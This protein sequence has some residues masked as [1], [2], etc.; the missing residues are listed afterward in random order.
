[1]NTKRLLKDLNGNN[2]GKLKQYIDGLNKEPRIAWYPSSGIDF[3]ALLFLSKQFSEKKPASNY[4]PDPPDL[5]IYTDYFLCEKP[6]F[7][8]V[9][10]S[11]TDNGNEITTESV[12]ELPNLDLQ[13]H[14]EIV[15]R[16]QGQKEITNRIF[17]LNIKIEN[18][19][20][21]SITFPVL[22]AFVEN[23]TFCCE[24]LIPNKTT[25]SQIIHVRY[26]GGC[27]GGGKAAGA[28]LL[29][30]LNTLKCGLFIT[31]GHHD[32][33]DGDFAAEMLYEAI[34]NGKD[35]KLTSIKVINEK[36]WSYHGNVSWNLVS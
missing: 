24:R 3:K 16:P 31:D 20:Y 9:G 21:G 5:F 28:W 34:R 36:R 4:V 2:S 29:R 32:W 35:A 26:G 14:R 13:L 11:I 15:T 19:T 17:F 12:E 10:N 25:I 6:D 1:M 7:L 23:E 33:Q 22:Y 30:V 18:S 27:G 8:V